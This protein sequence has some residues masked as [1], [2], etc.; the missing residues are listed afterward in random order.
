MYHMKKKVGGW[1][2]LL[3]KLTWFFF[4]PRPN[5]SDLDYGKEA[6]ERKTVAR[7]SRGNARLSQG[8]YI[9]R[10]DIERSMQRVLGYT[11]KYNDN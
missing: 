2:G 3:S 11:D 10:K 5:F 6:S 7:F 8:R 4:P 9:T 1:R